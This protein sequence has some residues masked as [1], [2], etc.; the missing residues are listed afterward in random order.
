VALTGGIATGKSYCLARFADLG[1]P[2]IDAD[3]LA[4]QA[5]APGTPGFD[6]VVARFGQDVLRRDGSL[7]RQALG[8]LVFAD[9]GTR[10]DLE[11]IVHP[12]VYGAIQSWFQS[13]GQS[14]DATVVAIADIPLLY[15]TGRENDFDSVIVTRCGPEQQ[16]ERLMKRPELSEQ[17]ARRRIES[18]MPMDA[19]AA[20]ADY[21]IDTSGSHEETNLQVLQVWQQARQKAE[22]TRHK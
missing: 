16:L 15:E 13:L 12:V 19:R 10:R 8:R 3:V 2:T 1:A 20:R 18:Q 21:V 11:A 22:G 5:V 6:A 9:E 7:D 14:G 17:D 4:K